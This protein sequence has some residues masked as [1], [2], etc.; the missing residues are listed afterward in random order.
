LRDSTKTRTTILNAA[1]ILFAESSFDLVSMRDV[2]AKARVPLGLINYHFVS[3]E[4]MFEAIIVRRSEE[5]NRARRDAFARISGRPSIGQIVD[6]FFRPYLQL[7]LQGGPGWRAYGR[8][9]AQTGQQARWGRL[10]TRCFLE[11]Q[12]IIP[13][14]LMDVEPRL[15]K[16]AAL[17]G[18]VH[19][20]SIM[21]GMFAEN[22]MLT[23]ISKRTYS[24]RDLDRAYE[25][26]LPFLIGA[27]EGLAALSARSGPISM[28][29]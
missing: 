21:V 24:S 5:L 14:A 26:V 22:E 29:A 13:G 8:L 10:L 11:T 27:F 6:V 15:T 28:R 2:A 23:V 17:R 12:E 4:K 20:V 18:Y 19:M 16:E 3:K 25:Y 1:E 7:T 9:L